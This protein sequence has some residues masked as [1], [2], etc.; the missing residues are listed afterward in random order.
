MGF[1][2]N[3]RLI[4]ETIFL[5]LLEFLLKTMK[6]KLR[7]NMTTIYFSSYH[8]HDHAIASPSIKQLHQQVNCIPLK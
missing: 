6:R 1:I 7:R 8:I 2:F 3:L 4:V 5:L